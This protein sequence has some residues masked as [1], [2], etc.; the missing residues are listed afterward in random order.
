MGKFWQRGI[1]RRGLFAGAAA[2]MGAAFAGK[3]FVERFGTQPPRLSEHGYLTPA[4]PDFIDVREFKK[5]MTVEGLNQTAE[6]YFAGAKNWDAFLAK[7][8][9]QI[10]GAP[11]L[12]NNVSHLLRG[13]DLLP[14]MTVLDFGAAS[15]WLT[16]WLTQLG[17][18]AIGL[19]VSQTALRM[20][21]ELYARQPVI[22]S[23]P[24]PRFLHFDGHRIDLPDA[25]VDRIL[26]LDVFHHLLN[27]D[28]VLRE[29][30]RILRP[31]GIA[32][33]SEPGP[34]HSRTP[35]AQFEMRNFKVLE[36]DVD[37]HRI[38]ASAQQ[39]GFQRLR[40]A[41]LN[42]QSLLLGLSDFDDYIQGGWANRRFA[43]MTWTEMQDRRMFFLHRTA[44]PPTYDSRGRVGIEGKMEVRVPATAKAG[45]P[46]LAQATITNSGRATWLPYSAPKGGVWLAV[47]RLDA[48]GTMLD[49]VFHR[50][51]LTPGEGRA[52]ASGE[53]V[54]FELHLP[55]LPQGRYI[56][57]F[58]LVGEA[59]G[60]FAYIGGSEPVRAIVQVQ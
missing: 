15:C 48:S 46:L 54:K 29:M 1:S 41:V 19:D 22:G 23:H 30:S 17:M 52:V 32:G 36:D 10:A 24:A 6:D 55:A 39:A 7:P 37:I 16:R 26:V 42:S 59:F 8:L 35:G 25:S 38:W 47:R 21:R 27:P 50:Q 49:R 31:G 58:D 2:V 51:T 53:T 5:T 57:E 40:I 56:L 45:E 12:L 9:G 3:W 60:S 28:E 33:F 14:G 44:Q 20:G 18:E 11:D 43:E 13:L 4:S 34:R